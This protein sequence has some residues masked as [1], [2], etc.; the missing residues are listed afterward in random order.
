LECAASREHEVAEVQ[1]DAASSDEAA[2][3]ST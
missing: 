1:N 2:L 3:A